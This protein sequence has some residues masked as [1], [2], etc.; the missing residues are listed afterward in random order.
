MHAPLLWCDIETTGLDPAADRLLEVGLALTDA[1]LRVVAETSLVLSCRNV[2]DLEMSHVVREMH[3]RSGLFDEVERSSLGLRAAEELL[4]AWVQEHHAE[5]LY[6]AGSGV[7]FDRGWLKHHMPALIQV[8]NYRNFDLTTLRYFFGAEKETAAHRALPDI[9][10][11]M[12]QLRDF[13]ARARQAGLVAV[14]AAS[15]VA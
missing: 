8:W 3:E 7:H 4:V 9:R 12:Q 1:N 11:S 15:L 2:R 10:Q 6:M 14:P 5:G 13:A